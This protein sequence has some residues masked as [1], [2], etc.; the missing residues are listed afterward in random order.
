MARR[1]YHF[2]R[3]WEGAGILSP[4]AGVIKWYVGRNL[5]GPINKR[6]DQ[7]RNATWNISGRERN[8]IAFLFLFV[9][10]LFQWLPLVKPSQKFTSCWVCSQQGPGALNHR[11]EKKA[12]KCIW[13]QWWP[14]QPKQQ[15][16]ETFDVPIFSVVQNRREKDHTTETREE[17]SYSLP[18]SCHSQW[19]SPH[20]HTQ[21]HSSRLPLGEAHLCKIWHHSNNGPNEPHTDHH[22]NY[23]EHRF[24]V[25]PRPVPFSKLNTV[26]SYHGIFPNGR[27]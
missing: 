24:F 22:S 26:T 6:Q 5:R 10:I 17:T 7:R 25:P 3:Q 13:V 16:S 27:T 12:E 14:K 8:D 19:P 11:A 15:Q 20:K 21:S 18:P 9:I 2:K 4:R 1:P 23:T